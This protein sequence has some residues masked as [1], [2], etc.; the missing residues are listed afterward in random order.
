[1]GFLAAVGFCGCYIPRSHHNGV[2]AALV[3]LTEPLDV[4]VNSRHVVLPLGLVMP[5][6][7][8]KHFTLAVPVMVLVVPTRNGLESEPVMVNLQSPHLVQ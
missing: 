2:Q 7:I 4:L 3:S 1:M 8:R 6:A 5:I